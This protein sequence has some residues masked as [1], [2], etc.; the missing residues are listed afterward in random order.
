MMFLSQVIFSQAY[1]QLAG[2]FDPSYDGM[3]KLTVA[4]RQAGMV[5][6]QHTY[7]LISGP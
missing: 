2:S 1:E 4:L 3:S 7:A 5:K 6:Q